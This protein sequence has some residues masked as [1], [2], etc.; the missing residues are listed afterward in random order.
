VNE[1][2]C[3]DDKRERAWITRGKARMTGGVGMTEGGDDGREHGN[4]SNL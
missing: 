3:L 2:W 1:S 4:D